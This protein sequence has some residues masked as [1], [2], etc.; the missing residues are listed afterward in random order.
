MTNFNLKLAKGSKI[1][2]ILYAPD[3]RQVLPS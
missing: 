1:K 3:S 2:I